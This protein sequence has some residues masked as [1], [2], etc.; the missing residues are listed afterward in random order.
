MHRPLDRTCARA[1]HASRFA[2][3]ACGVLAFAFYAMLP[4]AAQTYPNRPIKIIVPYPAGGPVDALARA[5]GEGFRERTGQMFIVES[6]PGA[7]TSI[8]AQTCKAA[9][10]DGYTICLL[11]STTLSI[12]PHLYKDLRYAP[13]DLA[14]ITNIA[15]A[16]AVFMLRNEVPAKTLGE[17]VEW[18]KKNPAKANYGSF[19]VGGETHLMAEWLNKKTGAQMTHV[20]FAGFAPALVAFDGGEIQVMMPVAIPM[21]IDKIRNGRAKG[22]MIMGDKRLDVLP[23]LPTIPELGMPPV[24]FVT[25]F[26]M[27]AP[28]GTPKPFIDK[29]N[30]ELRAIVAQKAFADR[31]ITASGMTAVTNTPE[32]FKAFLAGD[33]AK[34]RDLVATSG[35]TLDP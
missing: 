22:V 11:A 8:G 12:N 26:G 34:A 5:L 28:A 1:T 7:N 16:A 35:V 25:W 14:P 33:N 32:E 27:F 24:G 20:P 29:V 10:P 2:A 6:K 9:E 17:F 15:S 21:I 3:R 23:D 31:F 18:S 30:T 13:S 4:A 19:G